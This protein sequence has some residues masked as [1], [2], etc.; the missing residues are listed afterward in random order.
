MWKHKQVECVREDTPLDNSLEDERGEERGD[1][2]GDKLAA[3]FG[4]QSVDV[5]LEHHQKVT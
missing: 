1:R 4:N 2:G 3:C 5:I